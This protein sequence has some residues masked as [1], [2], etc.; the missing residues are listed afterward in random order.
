MIKKTF[1]TDQEAQLLLK[2]KL[3]KNWLIREQKPDIHIDYFIEIVENELPSGVMFCVQL[4]GSRQL[5]I[6]RDIVKLQFKSK[7]LS[8]YL[9]KIK[10]PVYLI[11]ADVNNNECYWLFLQEYI[12]SNIKPLVLKNQKNVTLKI[13]KVNTLNNIKK[14]QEQI[15]LDE[16]YIR[17]LFPSSIPAAIYAQKEHWKKLDPRIDVD[18]HHSGTNTSFKFN[19]KEKINFSFHVKKKKPDKFEEKIEEALNKGTAVEFDTKDVEV[20][21]SDL[22]SELMNDKNVEGKISI[23]PSRW[24][25]GSVLLETIDKNNNSSSILYNVNGKIFI[26]KTDFK[27]EGELENAPFKLTLLAPFRANKNKMIANVEMVFDYKKWINKSII[28][29]PYRERL[30]N[31]FNDLNNGLEL[32]VHIDFEGNTLYSTKKAFPPEPMIQSVHS[33]FQL[34]HQV[35]KIIE[36]TKTYLILPEEKHVT[37]DDWDTVETMYN[38]I[39]KGQHRKNA[40]MVKFKTW[41]IPGLEM[42]KKIKSGKS[43]DGAIRLHTHSKFRLFG[44]EVEFGNMQYE[45]TNSKLIT[46]INKDNFIT[47]ADKRESIELEWEGCKCSELIITKV[48]Q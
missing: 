41:I 40:E 13:P 2:Q 20:R 19:P 47:L 9:E 25:N 45:I 23:K 33:F 42:I 24:V 30:Y 12:K 15:Y 28:F 37:E 48:N 17:E 5:N 29:L 8:Y 34:I 10:N 44:Q 1:E 11:V 16:K 31:L 6:K 32:I 43:L 38:I 46:M 27:F 36:Y 35:V 3:P 22:L 21:G 14:F 18:I 4:K 7:Q 26:G 39:T